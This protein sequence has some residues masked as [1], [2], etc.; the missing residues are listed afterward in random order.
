MKRIW[1]I[2]FALAAG[3]QEFVVFSNPG[4]APQASGPDSFPLAPHLP[5]HIPPGLSGFERLRVEAAG[6]DI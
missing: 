2:G 3:A 1:M 6:A 4:E 5:A